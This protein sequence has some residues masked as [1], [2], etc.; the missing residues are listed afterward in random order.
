MAEESDF[1]KRAKAKLKLVE[2]PPP[3][4]VKVWD[5]DLIPDVDE[6]ARAPALMELD[7]LLESLPWQTYYDTYIGKPRPGKLVHG[8]EMISCPFH[9][10]PD[11][12]PSASINLTTEKWHCHGCAQGGDKYDLANIGLGYPI[13]GANKDFFKMKVQVAKDQGFDVEKIQGKE[14]AIPFRTEEDGDAEPLTQ[15]DLVAAGITSNVYPLPGV[16]LPKPIELIPA[17]DWRALIPPDTFLYDYVGVGALDDLPEEY[18]FWCG[19][20]AIGL[21]CGRDAT[22]RDRPTVKPNLFVCLLGATGLGK[23]KS[24]RL[25][26]E[27]LR[28][29]VPYDWS[30]DKSKGVRTISSPGSGEILVDAMKH[31]I[32]DISAPKGTRPEPWPVRGL[33]RVDELSAI[34]GRTGRNGSV[35]KPILMDFF[36]CGANPTIMSRG[37][38]VVEA[39]EPFLSLVTTSQNAALSSLLTSTDADSG[40]LNRFV[41]VNGKP[42][43]LNAFNDVEQDLTI[44]IDRLKKIHIWSLMRNRAV[45]VSDDGKARWAEFFA[46]TLEPIKTSEDNPMLGRIDLLMKKIMLLFAINEQSS[47]VTLAM[48]E[49]TISLYLYL[50]SCYRQSEADIYTSLGDAVGNRIIEVCNSLKAGSGRWPTA[51][52]IS[53]AI[54]KKFTREQVDKTLDVL[55]RLGHVEKLAVPTTSKGGAPTSRYAVAD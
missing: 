30:D 29:A 49:R 23:S 20:L 3:P 17:I 16:I 47:T 55:V 37:H 41:F 54:G 19:L 1:L 53:K 31:E 46:E 21:A 8:E 10:H 15:E 35:L 52:D 18:H 33:L 43:Q 26:L 22:L 50:L 51:R 38:G 9:D 32:I 44:P 27:V 42:K 6:P 2:P 14:V 48:V 39:Y 7:A 28:G 12:N 13:G 11:K 25:L 24:I 5:A 45:T 34:S 40:Y 36:D 4:L